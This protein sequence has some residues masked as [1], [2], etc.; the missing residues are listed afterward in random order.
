MVTRRPED[1]DVGV[2]HQ[3]RGHPEVILFVSCLKV[4]RLLL[5]LGFDSV[6]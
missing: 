4:K 6:Y 5:K 1:K 3:Y 2:F